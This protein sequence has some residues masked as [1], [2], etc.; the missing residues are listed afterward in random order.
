MGKKRDFYTVSE[1]AEFL[2]VHINTIYNG[3]KNGRIQAFRVGR[4]K[5]SSFRIPSSE[6]QR[7]SLFDLEEVIQNIV[8]KRMRKE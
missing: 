5:H 3:I 4:G 2:S 8:E 1:F 7:M 6:I